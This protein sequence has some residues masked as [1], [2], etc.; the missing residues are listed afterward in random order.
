MPFSRNG[1]T[2]SRWVNSQRLEQAKGFTLVELLVV[3]AII[4]IL[5][6]LLLPAVQAAREAARRMQCSNN[7]KQL[8]LAMHN[9]H[10]GQGQ[11]PPGQNYQLGII[12]NSNKDKFCWFQEMLPFVEQQALY[13]KYKAHVASGGEVWWTP[14]RWTSIPTF[15]CP[16]DGANPKIVTGGWSQSPGGEPE[17]SQGWS[18]NLVVLAGSTVFNPTSDTNG[19]NLDGLFF[20]KSAVRID[21]IRDGSTNTL[22][23]GEIIIVRDIGVGQQISGGNSVT[24]KHDNRGRY[25]NV[26][27]GTT[28]FSTLYPPN[29]SVGDR[30]TW[31]VDT[32]Q[33]PCQSLGTDN[34]V[35]SLRSY[36]PGGVN[37]VLADGSVHFISDYID[38]Q[39]YKNYG[40]RAGGEVPAA[41]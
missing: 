33:A 31:C 11:L 39:T 16:S 17:N 40:T 3:I 30:G 21:D 9:F 6:A 15:M 2:M 13:D 1:A 5:V 20:A 29:T 22:L 36:H 18:G 10:A 26:H 7:L 41:L 24:Q 27:Q 8:G 32:E 19:E 37:A 23:G 14:D 28:L 34:L 25:W 38:A 12:S 4:G 35:Q